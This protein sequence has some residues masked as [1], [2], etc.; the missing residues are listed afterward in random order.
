MAISHG[1][2]RR[3]SIIALLLTAT[4]VLS[5]VAAGASTVAATDDQEDTYSVVQ[6]DQCTTIEPVGHGHQSVEEFYDYRHPDTD[7]S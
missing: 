4:M 2:T 1:T 5:V 7:P 3:G 6:G